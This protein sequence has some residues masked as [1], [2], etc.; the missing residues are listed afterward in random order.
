[1]EKTFLTHRDKHFDVDA[2][3]FKLTPHRHLAHMTD[4]VTLK[5][6]LQPKNNAPIL[7]NRLASASREGSEIL[8]L[9]DQRPAE[10]EG[11]DTLLRVSEN[12]PLRPQFSLH[13]PASY[14]AQFPIHDRH[15]LQRQLDH[16]VTMN[17]KFNGVSFPFPADPRS[18]RTLF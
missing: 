13:P 2:A 8:S 6:K 18:V 12:S 10:R 4:K 7:L 9:R 11:V 16:W 15:R 17:S 1:M 14:P 5:P 3:P